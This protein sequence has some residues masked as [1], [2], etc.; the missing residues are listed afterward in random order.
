[1]NGGGTDFPSPQ[2]NGGDFLLSLLQKPC[3]L[4]PS[5]SPTTQQSPI[6][7]LAVVMMGPI[8]LTNSHD[9]PD[10]HPH[11]LPPTDGVS[12]AEYLRRLGFPIESSSN[13]NS[14]V[15]ELKLQFGSL[16]TVS[17]ATTS[18][19]VSL[20]TFLGFGENSNGR[21]NADHELLALLQNS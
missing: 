15:Q 19:E 7:D 4:Q 16:P 5:Q 12:L 1:M 18:H 21:G 3:N 9:H 13:N 17:Y 20:N 6:I 10:F 2:P 14:F 11:H 8:I